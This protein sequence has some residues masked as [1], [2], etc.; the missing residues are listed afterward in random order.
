[1]DLKTKVRRHNNSG[2]MSVGVLLTNL[3]QELG[4]MT[5]TMYSAFGKEDIFGVISGAG[6]RG[7]AR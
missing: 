7:Q 6:F 4:S 3:S 1:M 5:Q 2:L